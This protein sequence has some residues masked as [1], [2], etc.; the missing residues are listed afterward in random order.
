ME[1]NRSHQIER[2]KQGIFINLPHQDGFNGS[3]I[4][5]H[6]NW[7]CAY[8][9]GNGK[10]AFPFVSHLCVLDKNYQTIK[11]LNS[12]QKIEDPKLFKHPD[13]RI[14]M[15]NSCWD[16]D[17]KVTCFGVSVIMNKKEELIYNWSNLSLQQEKKW[18]KNWIPFLYNEQI[19]LIYSISP[20][21]VLKLIEN[22]ENCFTTKTAYEET[23]NPQ[24]WSSVIRGNASAIFLKDSYLGIWHTPKYEIGFF[25]FNQNP[26]FI[27]FAISKY[28]WICGKDANYKLD[29]LPNNLSDFFAMSL[30]KK[31]DKILITI[32]ENDQCLKIWE[33]SIE[34]IFKEF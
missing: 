6:N 25:L 21:R 23:W 30:N 15:F 27:P 12:Y 11:Y 31:E 13:G 8:R 19:Y 28:P 17:R 18:Q 29:T 10:N 7:L 4:P 2:I 26:P 1:I 20:W 24:T 9:T 5:F 3:I 14:L 33:V 34:E 16:A 22:N 32:G